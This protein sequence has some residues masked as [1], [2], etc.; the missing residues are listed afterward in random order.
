MKYN[1]SV[2]FVVSC[3]FFIGTHKEKNDGRICTHKLGSKRVKSDKY[4]PFGG[5]VKNDPPTPTNPQM[6]TILHRPRPTQAIFFY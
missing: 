4:V 6:R 5:F 2:T 1:L 3:P